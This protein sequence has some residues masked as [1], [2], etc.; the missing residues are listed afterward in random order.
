MRTSVDV[1]ERFIQK[2][3]NWIL[4]QLS[5]DYGYSDLSSYKFILVKGEKLPLIF[6]NENR[7]GK[8]YVVVK[9]ITDIKKLYI[10]SFGEEFLELFKQ[11]SE[12]S[13]LKASKVS[14]KSYKS[15][16]GCCDKNKQIIFNYKLLMLP[17][18]LWQ[19]VIVHEL[20]HTVF[21]DHSKNFHALANTVLPNFS[22]L[23]KEIK[24]YN[25]ITR[26]Y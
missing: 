4:K 9:K 17:I 1:I 19:C 21:M 8:D 16:W 7:L 24:K 26:L 14:F 11:V 13:G 6:G 12:H 15:R 3:R 2:K 10:D 20:C 25:I 22:V 23:Q 18:D 5:C